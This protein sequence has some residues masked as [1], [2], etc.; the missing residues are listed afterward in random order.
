M[1]FADEAAVPAQD[2]RLRSTLFDLWPM[3]F[4]GLRVTKLLPSFGIAA[5]LWPKLPSRFLQR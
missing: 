2:A 5:S 1:E 3:R 4:Q